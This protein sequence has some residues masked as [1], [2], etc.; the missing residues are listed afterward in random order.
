MVI[1][2]LTL[3]LVI[4][5]MNTICSTMRKRMLIGQLIISKW[6]VATLI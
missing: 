3:V 1:L 5:V 6:T 4:L 2:E